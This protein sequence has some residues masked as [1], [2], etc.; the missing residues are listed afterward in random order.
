MRGLSLYG[1]SVRGRSEL[2]RSVRG[3]SVARSVRGLSDAKRS[4]RGRSVP[5]RSWRGRSSRERGSRLAGRSLRCEESERR[6]ESGRSLRADEPERSV[7]LGVSAR[8]V[9][10]SP[11]STRRRSARFFGVPAIGRADPALCLGFGDFLDA[12]FEPALPVALA[13]VLRARSFF[14]FG[15]AVAGRVAGIT[16]PIETSRASRKGSAFDLSCAKTRW[17]ADS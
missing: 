5:T 1:R 12:L 17:R 14:G 13:V 6:G 11:N 3:R 8:V 2:K 15:R 7:R 16:I 10:V 4:L 9:R